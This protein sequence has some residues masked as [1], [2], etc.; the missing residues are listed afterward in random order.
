MIVCGGLDVKFG[1]HNVC[2]VAAECDYGSGD[3]IEF[4]S[5]LPFR[6]KINT[7]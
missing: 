7:D 1:P 4:F 5:F 3:L 2:I 6:H